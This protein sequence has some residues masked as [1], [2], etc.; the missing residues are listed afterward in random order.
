MRLAS[1]EPGVLPARLSGGEDGFTLIRLLVAIGI[2]S[3]L[4]AAASPNIA[5]VT[6]V[7]PVRSAA[8]QVYSE[9]QNAR[10]A[11]VTENRGYTF[12]V[13]GGGASYSVQAGSDAAVTIPLEAASQ[14]VTISAPSA[15]VFNS[16]G[17]AATSTAVTATNSL[18]D[19]SSVAV[20]P[21]GRVRIQ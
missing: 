2:V 1:R 21:A 10:S 8:R 13:V 15:I 17:T 14:G 16:R 18:G 11:A 9:L 7:Y 4:L 3:T 6:R 20:S 5:S 12:T 19:T